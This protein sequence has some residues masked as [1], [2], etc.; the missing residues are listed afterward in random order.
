MILEQIVFSLRL[1]IVARLILH[2]KYLP[3]V[4]I[5]TTIVLTTKAIAENTRTLLMDAKKPA[6]HAQVE[7]DQNNPLVI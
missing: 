2:Q 5:S 6:I 1:L 3:H 4:K 7:E